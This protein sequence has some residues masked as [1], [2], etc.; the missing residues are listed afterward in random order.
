MNLSPNEFFL[1]LADFTRRDMKGKETLGD[2][3][4][5]NPWEQPPSAIAA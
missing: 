1:R 2:S 5:Q 3:Y 4:E